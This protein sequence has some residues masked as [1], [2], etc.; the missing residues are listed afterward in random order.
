MP[1]GCQSTAHAHMIRCFLSQATMKLPRQANADHPMSQLAFHQDKAS[2]NS[3]N[4]DPDNQAG[5][6]DKGDGH[7]DTPPIRNSTIMLMATLR[8]V[9]TNN[10]YTRMIWE[11][12]SL[13][14]SSHSD[15]RVPNENDWVMQ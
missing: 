2:D 14:G 6:G 11:G 9:A 7:G 12:T 13:K 15:A 5:N 4:D 10:S 1:K 8:T 3:P